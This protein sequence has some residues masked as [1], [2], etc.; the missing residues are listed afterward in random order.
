MKIEEF[1]IGQWYYTTEYNN[2]W[3]F[4]GIKCE[5]DCP[6]HDRM[7][8]QDR[9][10]ERLDYISNRKYW[11][12]SIPADMEK[13]R[14]LLGSDAEK[15]LPS[16]LISLNT[17]KMKAEQLKNGVFVWEYRDTNT[18]IIEVKGSYLDNCR[19]INP[20]WSVGGSIISRFSFLGGDYYRVATPEEVSFLTRCLEAGKMV[21]RNN[22]NLFSIY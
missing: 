11:E 20:D 12:T 15:Y 8:R 7:Y 14:I 17:F 22:F 5:N 4:A 1:I 18:Y 3:R 2:Y 9:M 21:E 10:D 19:Y 16:S 13:F 6:L